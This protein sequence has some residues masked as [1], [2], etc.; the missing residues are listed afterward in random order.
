MSEVSSGSTREFQY[1][2]QLQH[3]FPFHQCPN[4]IRCKWYESMHTLTLGVVDS[5]MQVWLGLVQYPERMA[6]QWFTTCKQ[7]WLCNHNHNIRLSQSPNIVRTFFKVKK[8]LHFRCME[9]DSARSPNRLSWSISPI[10]AGNGGWSGSW[11]KPRAKRKNV[12]IPLGQSL[13][14]SQLCFCVSLLVAFHGTCQTDKSPTVQSWWECEVACCMTW[15]KILATLSHSKG[16]VG[17]G[18][19]QAE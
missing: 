12:A 5:S 15:F 6:F 14:S 8:H 18:S 7:F 4:H 17:W 9:T 10:M 13:D 11:E 1:L 16:D 2:L 3:L 19:L